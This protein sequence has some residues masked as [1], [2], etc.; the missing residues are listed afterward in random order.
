MTLRKCGAVGNLR[1]PCYEKRKMMAVLEAVHKSELHLDIGEWACRDI[2]ASNG[3]GPGQ[4]GKAEEGAGQEDRR[5]YEGS[6]LDA[7]AMKS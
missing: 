6:R 5:G 2:A 4:G 3:S 7:R 1:E